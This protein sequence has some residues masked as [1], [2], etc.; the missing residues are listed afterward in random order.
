ML[1][2]ADS[3]ASYIGR[4]RDDFDA[5]PAL[6]DGVLYQIVVLGEAAKAVVKADALL[7]AEISEVEWSLL[8]R[9]RDRLTHTYWATDREIVWLTATRDIPALREVLAA[10]IERLA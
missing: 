2:A 1:E 9:M 7:A 8:A 4:G 6:R 3:I 10:A 5:D